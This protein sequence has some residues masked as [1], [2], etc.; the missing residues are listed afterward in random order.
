MEFSLDQMEIG[1]ADGAGPNAQEDLTRA[2]I[3]H[4]QVLLMQR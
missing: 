2:G 3:R 4:R 1:V